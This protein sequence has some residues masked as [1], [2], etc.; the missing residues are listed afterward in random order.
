[1]WLGGA[2]G[3]GVLI[4][5]LPDGRWSG[6][7]AFSVGSGSAGLVLGVDYLECVAVLNT[8]QAVRAYAGEKSGVDIGAGLSVAAGPLSG[9]MGDG[10]SESDKKEVYMYTRSKGLY[11]GL[12]VD[13][14]IVRVKKEANEEFYGEK[15]ITADRIIKGDVKDGND[16]GVWPRG[17]DEL[18]TLVRKVAGGQ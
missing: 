16:P 12:T 7:S 17:A 18:L 4:A 9:S 15:G 11:G 13:G 1:M 5:R 10:G 8:P 14:T 6:P 3:S 2:A